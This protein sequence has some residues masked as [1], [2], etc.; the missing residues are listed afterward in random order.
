M[1]NFTLRSITGFLF[2][3][4]LIA[5]ITINTYS[6][7]AVF[8]VITLLALREFYHLSE[9]SGA[10]PQKWMGIIS[11]FTLF[12]S[13][14]FHAY[15]GWNMGFLLLTVMGVCFFIAELYRKKPNPFT[16]IAYTLLGVIYVALPFSLL[17]YLVFPNGDQQFHPE[18]VLGIFVMIWANDS[19]AYVVGVNFG[20]NRLFERISPKK[21]W[22]GS[23]GG[24]ISALIIAWVCSLLCNDLSL[25]HW[26]V[27]ALIVVF[28]GSMGDLTESLFKRSINIKDSGN[29]LPGHG[30]ILDR[31]DAVF[32]AAPMVFVY[33]QIIKQIFH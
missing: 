27:I 31:F 18:I 3:T 12:S 28:F 16:N 25:I 8:T 32:L 6:F 30:G 33:L 10:S 17:N 29:I 26:S 22:E 4:V 23:I 21:S 9:K 7:L 11:G 19:G 14:F 1:S 2:I 13:C 20:K 24:A 5:G 15:M